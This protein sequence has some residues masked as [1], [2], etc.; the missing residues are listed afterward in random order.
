MDEPGSLDLQVALAVRVNTLAERAQELIE[1]IEGQ[2]G[3]S[4]RF[5]PELRSVHEA[6]IDL[7]DVITLA[8]ERRADPPA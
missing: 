3:L 8:E 6:L 1:A 5:A 7:R 2:A 4:E